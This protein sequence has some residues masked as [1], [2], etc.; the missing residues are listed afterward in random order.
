M[1]TGCKPTADVNPAADANQP[2]VKSAARHR[3]RIFAL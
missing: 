1:E 3:V 2:V